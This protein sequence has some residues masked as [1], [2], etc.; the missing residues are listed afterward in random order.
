MLTA[1]WV[2]RQPASRALRITDL[3]RR[4]LQQTLGIDL[5]R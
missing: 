5:E 1:R 4:Q 2:T 3:G